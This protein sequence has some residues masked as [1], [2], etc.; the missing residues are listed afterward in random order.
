[1][2]E[3]ADIIERC[4]RFAW[5]VD[6]QEWQELRGLFTEKILVDYTSLNG[7]EPAHVAADDIVGAWAGFLSGFDVTQ[8]L[9]TNQLVTVSG[10]TAV[11]TAA[12]QATHRLSSAAGGSLWT[13]GGDYRFELVRSDAGWLISAVTMT[14]TWGDGN[15]HLMT[16]AGGAG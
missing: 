5:H 10:D 12:F 8:H 14:A 6:H 11:C 1:M 13:L 4:T 9:I 2:T 15:Q 16:L 7:G 3:K